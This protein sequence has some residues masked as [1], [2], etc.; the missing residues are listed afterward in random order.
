MLRTAAIET[1]SGEW[2]C[3]FS[4]RPVVRR[5]AACRSEFGSGMR[6]SRQQ[7]EW[8]RRWRRRGAAAER[9]GENHA[10]ERYGGAW[11]DGEFSGERD[12]GYEYIGELEC[13]RSGRRERAIGN[14]FGGRTI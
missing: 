5:D 12:G 9:S 7:R 2:R 11:R 14:D 4:V 3:R 13:E 1:L 8:R 6:R 10:G